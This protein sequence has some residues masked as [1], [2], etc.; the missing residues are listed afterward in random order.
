MSKIKIAIKNRWTGSII[1]EYEKENNSIRE[2]VQEYIR[3]ELAAGKWRADLTDANLTDAILEH[4][5]WDQA[6]TWPRGFK[7]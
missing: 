7:P 3:Q 2:T 6:T 5:V 1:F 4:A